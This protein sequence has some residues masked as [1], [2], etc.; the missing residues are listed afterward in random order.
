MYTSPGQRILDAATVL[1]QID[2]V[3]VL[4]RRLADD[5]GD[6]IASSQLEAIFR[7][8]EHWDKLVD[9]LLDR[10]ES[11]GEAESVSTLTYVAEIYH[12]KLADSEAALIV[13]QTAF[14]RR[15]DSATLAEALDE[16]A[17][18]TGC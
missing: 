8:G 18:L 16:L 14:A 2:D 6:L 7:Q 13:L 1:E 9:L 4:Q 17:S 10:A 3:G 12:R 11:L 15:P 5:P